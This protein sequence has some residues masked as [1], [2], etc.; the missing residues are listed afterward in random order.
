[1]PQKKSA[2]KILQ[3]CNKP[4]FP[5][6]DGGAIGMN[7]V[8]EGLIEA[9]FN[10][11]I[12]SANSKKHFVEVANLPNEY[13]TKTSFEAVMVDLEIHPVKAIMNLLFPIGHT[14]LFGFTIMN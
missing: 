7:N 12:L 6:K 3:F 8:S 4:S 14:I 10:L 5:P 11:K 2:L 1:M 13:I 9:G